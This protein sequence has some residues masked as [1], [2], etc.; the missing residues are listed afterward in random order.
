M[1]DKVIEVYRAAIG[2]PLAFDGSKT[3]N[4]PPVQGLL[5]L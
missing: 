1:I 5:E 4:R 2:Q 3:A